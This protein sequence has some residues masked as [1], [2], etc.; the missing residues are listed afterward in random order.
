MKKE[1]YLGLAQTKKTGSCP[2]NIKNNK[3]EKIFHCL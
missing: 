1:T 2:V 3:E